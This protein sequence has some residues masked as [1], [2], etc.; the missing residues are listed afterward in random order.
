MKPH[1]HPNPPPD[2][3]VLCEVFAVVVCLMLMVSRLC[4]QSDLL[5]TVVIAN[6][7][8]TEAQESSE[9]IVAENQFLRDRNDALQDELRALEAEV[10]RLHRERDTASGIRGRVFNTVDRELQR[11]GRDYSNLGGNKA[12]ISVKQLIHSIEEQVKNPSPIAEP[13]SPTSPTP[14]DGS[15]PRRNSND[16]VS[17]LASV[18]RACSEGPSATDSSLKSLLRNKTTNKDPRQSLTHRC[19]SNPIIAQF[20]ILQ[21]YIRFLFRHTISNIIY[22]SAPAVTS[23]RRESSPC[24]GDKKPYTS[25]LKEPPSSRTRHSSFGFV[26]ICSQKQYR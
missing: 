1:Q 19:L 23:E 5:R 6:E 2:L 11:L 18:E 10:E 20:F 9:Q 4:L 7:F 25:I 15:K 22:E 14:S 3:T 16:S 13:S 8:K 17:S 26:R 24:S 21:S 12:N